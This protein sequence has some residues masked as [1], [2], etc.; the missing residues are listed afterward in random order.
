[1]LHQDRRERQVISPTY[2]GPILD[3]VEDPD[4]CM[5]V[6]QA[7]DTRVVVRYLQSQRI[8]YFVHTKHV[9]AELLISVK[10]FGTVS[11]YVGG[12]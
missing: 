9:Y 3:V 4:P 6:E 10:V 12:G 1:M 2:G 8:L 11:A 7:L 5:K